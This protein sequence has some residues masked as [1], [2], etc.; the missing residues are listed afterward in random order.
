MKIGFTQVHNPA[1]VCPH[2]RRL[3]MKYPDFNTA[4]ELHR[5]LD[6]VQEASVQGL[7][8]AIA[9]RVDPL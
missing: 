3:A 1:H 4:V 8:A 6:N 2:H 7:A 5:F 9:Y